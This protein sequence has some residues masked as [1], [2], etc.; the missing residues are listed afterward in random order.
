MRPGK[1]RPYRSGGAS[2]RIYQLILRLAS[3]VPPHGATVLPGPFLGGFFGTSGCFCGLRELGANAKA[4]P[5]AFGEMD[6]RPAAD[7]F[8]GAR[9]DR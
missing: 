4:D 8:N 7:R 9:R 5:K 2:L 3:I 6:R 1:G